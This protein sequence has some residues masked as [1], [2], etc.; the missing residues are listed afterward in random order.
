MMLFE[1]KGYIGIVP[2]VESGDEL[3]LKT[4]FPSRKYTQLWKEGRL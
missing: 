4:L 1:C 3:F 2:F